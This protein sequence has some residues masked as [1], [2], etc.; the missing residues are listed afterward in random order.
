MVTRPTRPGVRLRR[1]VS[2]TS[3]GQRRGI[4][5]PVSALELNPGQESAM[6]ASREPE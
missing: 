1:Y 2:A 4:G 6:L 3:C 5:I